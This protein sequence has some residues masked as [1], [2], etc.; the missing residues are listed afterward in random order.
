MLRVTS[1][2]V[3]YR[4][5]ALHQNRHRPRSHC[6]IITRITELLDIGARQYT[7]TGNLF[8]NP[9]SLAMDN[10]LAQL[11]TD[12]EQYHRDIAFV[13]ETWLKKQHTDALFKISGFKLT[14]FDR[15]KRRGGGVCAAVLKQLTIMKR[16]SRRLTSDV[17]RPLPPI[18]SCSGREL[19]LPVV[20]N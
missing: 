3:I 12:L 16:L 10:A 18:T 5:Y 14:R 4:C 20:M 9:T 7:T 2:R 19:N 1:F 17:A 13:C 8:Y 6:V 15:V 11:K